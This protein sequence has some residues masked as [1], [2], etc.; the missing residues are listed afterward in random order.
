MANACT[1]RRPL[2]IDDICFQASKTTYNCEALRAVLHMGGGAGAESLATR[3][4]KAYDALD[5]DLL[6]KRARTRQCLMR[7]ED[8][9]I[10]AN[11]AQ[12]IQPQR[13]DAYQVLADLLVAMN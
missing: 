10:D 7:Y 2:L 11:L 5:Y 8:A 4:L 13:L 1:E 6:L 12:N 3:M 9:V